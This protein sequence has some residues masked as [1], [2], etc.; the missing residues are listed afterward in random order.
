M[1]VLCL[2]QVFGCTV[3][4]DLGNGAIHFALFTTVSEL[5]TRFFATTKQLVLP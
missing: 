2:L 1:M 5:N 3:L 4:M